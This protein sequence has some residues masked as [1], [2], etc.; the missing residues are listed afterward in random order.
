V[1]RGLGVSPYEAMAHS[2]DNLSVT[3][4]DHDGAGWSVQAINHIP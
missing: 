1:Q 4:L 3:R 2:I